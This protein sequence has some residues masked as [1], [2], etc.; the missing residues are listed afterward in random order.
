VEL[1]DR[2]ARVV[3]DELRRIQIEQMRRVAAAHWEAAERD[4]MYGE[5]TNKPNG[6]VACRTLPS[7]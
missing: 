4:G 3:A 1:S 5:G 7:S 6:V 2:A